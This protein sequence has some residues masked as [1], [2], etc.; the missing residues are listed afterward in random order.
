MSDDLIHPLPT[1]NEHAE[2]DA[3]RRLWALLRAVVAAGPVPRDRKTGLALDDTGRLRAV[4][5]AAPD[6]VLQCGAGR[7]RAS[8][9]QPNAVRDLVALYAP[10]LEAAGD[11]PFVL[12]HLGQS[13]DAQIATRTGDSH[14]VN[15]PADIVHLHRLRALSDAVIIGAGTAT[16]DD[17]R[18]TTRRVEGPNPARVVIDPGRR[19][20]ATLGLFN[21][22]A[23]PTLVACA[24]EHVRPTD[25]RDRIIG[26]A[27]DG[28]GL[29]LPDLVDQL[30]ARGLRRLFVEGGGITVSRWLAAGCVDRL[31]LAIAPVLIGDGRPALHLPAVPRMAD[32]PRPPARAFRLGDDLLWDLDLRADPDVSSAASGAGAFWPKAIG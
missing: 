16:A 26:V 9:T 12:A 19:A 3:S 13:I 11:R 28:D 29:A 32:C 1:G 21:D 5:P 6:A 18:L 8:D 24:R 15:G 25:D 22:G 31:H 23:A 27:R 14:F 7:I 20:P 17:P 10:L 2:P 4:D 30:L